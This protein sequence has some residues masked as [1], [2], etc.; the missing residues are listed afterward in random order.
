MYMMF[1]GGKLV[2]IGNK[3]NGFSTAPEDFEKEIAK[4]NKQAR[5]NIFLPADFRFI[6]PRHASL[7]DV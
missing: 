7:S 3:F 5:K 4:Q 6:D 2:F 1:Y